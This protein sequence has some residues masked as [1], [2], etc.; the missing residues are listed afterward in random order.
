MKKITLLLL[1][2]FIA[3]FAFGQGGSMQG[4]IDAALG[5]SFA[6]QQNQLEPIIEELKKDES[7]N[8]YWIAYSKL[9]S[10]VFYQQTGDK[11][12]A[13]ESVEEGIK[14]LQDIKEKDSEEHA[15]LGYLLGFSITFDP[16]NAPLLAAKSNR[17]YEA[18]LKKNPNNLRAY[19]GLGESD[20]HKP[21]A[22]GGGE[23]VEEFLSKAI[24]LPDSSVENGPT[25][26]KNSAYYTLASFYKREGDSDK[27]KMYC[28]Q[29]LSKYPNDARLNQLKQSF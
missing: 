17:E 9:L 22:Y 12:K 29:G 4:K 10:G 23:K 15:L 3:A 21:A 24:S 2:C 8:T 13:G 25:W 28:M 5:Q 27:A 20:F 11:N 14:L 26:G 6:T 1:T 16:S 7:G 18:S 19:L